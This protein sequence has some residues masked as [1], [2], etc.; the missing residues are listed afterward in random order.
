[1]AFVV[2][3]AC[4]KCKFQD[5]LQSCP[6]T[7]FYE[8]ENMLVIHPEECID[9]GACEPECPAEAIIRDTGPDGD[10]WLEFNRKYSQIWPNIK[11]AHEVAADAEDWL[12]VPNKLETEFSPEPAAR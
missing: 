11:V 9:C 1:M 2:T 6:V 10:K 5:C 12:E 8:G 4:I 7:C 3:E